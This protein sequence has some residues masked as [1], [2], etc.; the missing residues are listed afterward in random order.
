M[1]ASDKLLL[2]F[3][4][5]VST[6]DFMVLMFGCHMLML[7][8]LWM[9]QATDINFT[10]HAKLARVFVQRDYNL[11]KETIDRCTRR[12]EISSLFTR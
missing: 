2:V 8:A 9:T 12:N 5:L 3:Y 4:S 1:L 11:N 10:E 6:I 7:L